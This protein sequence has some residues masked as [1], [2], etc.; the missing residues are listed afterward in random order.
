MPIYEYKCDQCGTRFESLRSMKDAD[1][2]I[3]C[4]QCFSLDTH[5]V[6]SACYS[7]TESVRSNSSSSGCSGCSGGSCASCGH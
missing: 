3:E 6:I 5:R 4:K 1:A 7:K 2:R